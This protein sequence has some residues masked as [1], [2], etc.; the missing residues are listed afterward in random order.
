MA[1]HL[2]LHD[3]Q[4]KIPKHFQEI[5]STNNYCDITLVCEDGS[6]VDAH[7]VILT[8]GS[9]FFRTVLSTVR[10]HPQL[11]LYMRGVGKAQLELLI[12]YLY[13][14]EVKVE[15]E[16]LT[17][18]LQLAGELG[19][20]GLLEHGQ[21]EEEFDPGSEVQK[22]HPEEDKF[23]CEPSFEKNS[24]PLNNQQINFE[25]YGN[26]AQQ[27]D[28]NSSFRITKNPSLVWQ[29]AQ[30]K[31]GGAQCNYCGNIYMVYKG[32]TTGILNHIIKVHE[33][34]PEVQELK[35][36]QEKKYLQRQNMQR[37][38][39]FEKVVNIEE[40]QPSS[41][42]SY[43]NEDIHEKHSDGMKLDYNLDATFYA[44]EAKQ[45]QEM[46]N[47]DDDSLRKKV[48]NREPRKV[49]KETSLIWN[50]AYRFETEA[51]CKYCGK[52]YQTKGNSTSVWRHVL[53]MHGDNPN[54]KALK[55]KQEQTKK[56]RQQT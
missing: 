32:S 18:F 49:I 6:V 23:E 29:F 3:F 5:R 54:V 35:K 47:K 43:I 46:I 26:N 20:E 51:E 10:S 11:L 39:R 45:I 53:E 13:C 4:K 27:E 50:H 21:K 30:R 48:E 28:G 56:E 33:N 24:G 37:N 16:E 15:Q 14:G 42:L 8:L 1:A 55:I 25:R 31:K 40:S 22:L 17:S 38:H 52:V 36:E 34:N 19:I 41:E 12:D 44:D 2:T 7:R 9:I